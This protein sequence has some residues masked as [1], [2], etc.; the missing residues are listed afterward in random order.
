MSPPIIL[1]LILSA[2]FGGLTSLF[3]VVAL[4][5]DYWENVKYDAEKLRNLPNLVNGSIFND[6]EGFYKIVL[7]GGTG[8]KTTY[9]LRNSYGGIWKICDKMTGERTLV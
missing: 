1:V 5:T 4:S 3:M 7:A 8:N 2:F 9:V 6:E